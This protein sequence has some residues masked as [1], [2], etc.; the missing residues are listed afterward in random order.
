MKG[1]VICINGVDMRKINLERKIDLA[2][3]ELIQ[4]NEV[5]SIEAYK[6]HIERTLSILFIVDDDVIEERSTYYCLSEIERN[7][8]NYLLEKEIRK[9]ENGNK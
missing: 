5:R 4:V 6:Y 3:K 2:I 1:L 9:N 7:L 8:K